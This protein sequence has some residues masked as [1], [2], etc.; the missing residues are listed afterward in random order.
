MTIR[1]DFTV[2]FSV[3]PRIMTIASPS[4]TVS[5]QDLH[6]TLIDIESRPRN[7]SF[8]RLISSAGKE[9]LTGGLQVGITATL[10]NAKVAFAARAGPSFVQ[11]T[12]TG[13]NL[14]AVD[15]VGAA[16][17]PIQTTAFTQVVL[18]NAVSAVIANEW[19]ATEKSTL[20]ADMS[21]I[22]KVEQ[23]RWLIDEA[24]N[25]MVIFD[26]D[27]TTPLLT[28]DLKDVLGAATSTNVF[29]RVPV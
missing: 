17:D 9:T 24:T 8:L 15:G 13:G 26:T 29:E 23:G 12:I 2:D 5:I 4:V 10:Q 19:T 22:K 25:T 6:D 20:L 28:F 3:S 14:V 27:G 11:C 21:L 16:I 18:T 7:M 1:T